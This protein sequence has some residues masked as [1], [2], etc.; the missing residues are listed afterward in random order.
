MTHSIFLFVYFGGI[1]FTLYQIYYA[2]SD[3]KSTQ[4][5]HPSDP[6]QFYSKS[7][8]SAPPTPTKVQQTAPQAADDI[9]KA[10]ATNASLQRSQSANGAAG[11]TAN[12]STGARR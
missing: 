2:N 12:A 7:K 8:P 6:S 3:L 1:W 5:F 9:G 10:A 4:W 11:R